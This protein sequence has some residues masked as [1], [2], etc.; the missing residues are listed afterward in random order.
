LKSVDDAGELEEESGAVA[1]ES[2][3]LP[4]DAEVLAG[5]AAGEEIETTT[6]DFVPLGDV[7]AFATSCSCQ[8]SMIV[9]SGISV[10]LGSNSA[11]VVV[12]GGSGEPG[13]QHV[14]PVRVGFGEEHMLESGAS[15]S[16]VH[17]AA[18]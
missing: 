4:C 5:E 15:E 10:R 1:V 7:S 3:S 2:S 9:P 11:Y 13:S 12:D 8:F 17:P 18:S 14:P 16:F 6:G